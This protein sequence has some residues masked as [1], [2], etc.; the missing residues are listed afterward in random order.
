MPCIDLSYGGE[1]HLLGILPLHASR[2]V[3]LPMSTAASS[4]NTRIPSPAGGSGPGRLAEQPDILGNI[5]RCWQ[6]RPVRTA[7]SARRPSPCTPALEH[8]R[9]VNHNSTFFVLE[10]QLI[11]SPQRR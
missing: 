11:S 5:C 2:R 6:T 8:F 7:C 10:S 1:Q 9:S 4:R 3:T